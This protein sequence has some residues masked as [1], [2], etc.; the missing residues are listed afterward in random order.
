M[1]NK[2]DCRECPSG[3]YCETTKLTKASGPCMEGYYCPTGSKNSNAKACLSAM[4][5]PTGSSEPKYCEDGN[6]TGWELAAACAVC[7]PRY[8][9]IA[10]T[11]VPGLY[12]VILIRLYISLKYTKP[13]FYFLPDGGYTVNYV[14]MYVFVCACMHV[15]VCIN[16]C[17]THTHTYKHIYIYNLYIHTIIDFFVGVNNS[18]IHKC[19]AGFYCPEG[20]GRN[21]T[22]C[23]LGTYSNIPALA[24]EKEC[25]PCAAGKY[26]RGLNLTSPSD[27]C[28]AGYY[29]VSG[30]DTPFP[31]QT[32]LTHCPL[33]YVHLSIGGKCPPGFYCPT[34]SHSYTGKVIL[35]Y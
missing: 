22:P 6:Y 28:T 14:Y 13:V 30:V 20:T 9:C 1:T 16:V 18:G 12:L 27:N 32:N 4:H 3:S 21:P 10:E 11:V 17:I 33:N 26:C 35:L 34:G 23:P 2:T 31:E 29:C 24:E 8:Y 19:P 25:T 15:C 5:C 7:P